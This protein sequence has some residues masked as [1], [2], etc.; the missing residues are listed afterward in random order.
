[1]KTWTGKPTMTPTTEPNHDAPLPEK[2]EENEQARREAT[3]R[4]K[5][6]QRRSLRGVWY[7]TLFLGV[8]L[9]AQQGFSH[10]PDF[11]ASIKHLLGAPPSA[12]MISGLLI[13]YSF[14]ALILIL[15]RMTAGTG[16][17]SGL[18]HVGYLVVFYAFYH[19]SHALDDNFYAVLAAGITILAL[20]SYHVWT[21]HQE[22]IRKEKQYIIRLDRMREWKKG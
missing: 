9:A 4:I 14:S 20:E 16:A 22:Q 18:S 17:F 6:F 10:L 21:W 2:P 1:M 3:G 8:S 19:F 15:G 11:P 12:M 7:L 13:V 5:Q